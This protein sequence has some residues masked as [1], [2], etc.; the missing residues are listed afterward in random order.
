M[1]ARD[2]HPQ[3]PTLF[4]LWPKPDLHIPP[5]ITMPP[6]YELR[7]YRPGDESAWL[8]IQAHNEY[9]DSSHDLKRELHDY[10]DVLLPRGLFFVIHTESGQAVATAG[11]VHNTRGGMF[12]F[13]GELA[14][15]ATTPPHRRRG[16][17][18]AVS[19]AATTRLIEAGYDSIRL[20]VEDERLAALRVYLKMGYQP[21]LYTAEIATRWQAICARIDWPYTPN[22]WPQQPV[23]PA[24]P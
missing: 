15:V 24:E 22:K 6:G 23:I 13:G 3:R 20:G 2:T 17:G 14:W 12:P 1:T 5:T 18:R 4:M 21:Y 19:A 9:S 7:P 11:A 10:M 16:L 8:A